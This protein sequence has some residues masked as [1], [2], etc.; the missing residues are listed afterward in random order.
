MIV[1]W[2]LAFFGALI[3]SALAMAGL[4][5]SVGCLNDS[6][7]SVSELDISGTG[8]MRVQNYGDHYRD[9]SGVTDGKYVYSMDRTW[10]AG[11]ET[12]QKSFVLT[13]SKGG[14]LLDRDIEMISGAGNKR[15]YRTT[16]IE[17]DFEAGSETTF[18]ITPAGVES[19]ESTVTLDVA[20]GTA[21]LDIRVMNLTNHGPATVMELQ[22]VGNFTMRSYYNLSYEE[23][24]K[25]LEDPLA[26]CFALDRDNIRDTTVPDS[27]YFLPPGY[28]M[29]DG[30][31][32]RSLNIPTIE[33][34]PEIS[35]NTTQPETVAPAA[36]KER[37]AKSS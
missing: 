16:N 30:K 35:A 14:T 21:K 23:Q 10:E 8:A 17:G 24:V 29:V 26:F 1:C 15:I 33:P 9:D 12:V 11:N 31:I 28:E 25:V 4:V 27:L 34:S 3:I 7:A 19:S 5:V 18:T 22:A 2:R 32:I 37:A 36:R 20:N 13:S 6:N